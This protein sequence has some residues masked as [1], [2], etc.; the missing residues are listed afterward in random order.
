MKK[1]IIRTTSAPAAVGPYSQA[2]KVGDMVFVSG[3]IPLDPKTGEI[4]MAD[5]QKQTRQ[6]LNNLM[7]VLAAGEASA[8]DI[9]KTTVYI[10]KMA[11]FPLMNQVYE[12][13]F[14]NDPPARA[15]V[16][17]SALPRGALVEVDAVAVIN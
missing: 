4:I 14:P 6:A 7:A 17:V 9:V 5:I 1:S 3:Q 11:D 8:A 13:F 15:C 10:T 16:E 2:V 12:E